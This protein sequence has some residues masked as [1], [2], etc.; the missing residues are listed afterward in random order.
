MNDTKRVRLIT[1]Y[2]AN[3]QL[4]VEQL[5]EA[6]S[7]CL[8]EMSRVNCFR[9]VYRAASNPQTLL[10]FVKTFK[11]FSY[12]RLLVAEF[13]LDLDKEGIAI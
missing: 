3:N 2:A 12:K 9:E 5:T 4:T 11:F 13:A 10:P 8:H 7:Y 6:T 1:K